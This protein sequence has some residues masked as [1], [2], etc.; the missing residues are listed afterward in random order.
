[1][2][3][4]IKIINLVFWK[5][6]HRINIPETI[7]ILQDQAVKIKIAFYNSL[8]YNKS[9]TIID[10]ITFKNNQTK[11]IKIYLSIQGDSSLTNNNNL[12]VREKHGL[13]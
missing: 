6:S 1:M 13:N 7:I 11:L 9:A 10:T 5:Q 4:I 12:Q 2:I 8:K 3:H